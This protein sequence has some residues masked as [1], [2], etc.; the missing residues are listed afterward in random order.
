MRGVMR[1]T[2]SEKDS[3]MHFSE[4]KTEI[5]ANLENLEAIAQRTGGLVYLEQASYGEII[6]NGENY[7]IGS[8]KYSELKYIIHEKIIKEATNKAI[9]EKKKEITIDV[10]NVVDKAIDEYKR[11]SRIREQTE[12]VKRVY[13]KIKMNHLDDETKK[14]ALEILNTAKNSMLS[15][16]E[17][18]KLISELQDI[19]SKSLEKELEY[20]KKEVEKLEKD[21][22]LLRE[23]I[24]S[25]LTPEEVVEFLTEKE[26][27]KVEENA[28]ELVERLIPDFEEGEGDDC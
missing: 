12:L 9:S 17:L 5:V 25:K 28:R 24:K 10:S 11:L 14:R 21:I 6:V 27:Y 20:Y 18:H 26:R 13:N 8:D 1:I 22:E 2:L 7:K 4:A 19:K 15:D 23:I 16:N 3:Q